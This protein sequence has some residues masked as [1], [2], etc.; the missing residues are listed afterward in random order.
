MTI[1]SSPV[2]RLPFLE[3][4]V[5]VSLGVAYILTPAIFGPSV[6]PSLNTAPALRVPPAAASCF[7]VPTFRTRLGSL[8]TVVT[9]LL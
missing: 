9:T 4:L 5:A 2:S 7:K 1:A 6:S 3:I 8:R